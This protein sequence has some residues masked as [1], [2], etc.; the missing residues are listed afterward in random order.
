MVWTIL[1]CVCVFGV[2]LNWP[3]NYVHGGQAKITIIQHNLM[4]IDSAK[5]E[6]AFVHH[7]TD[8]VAMTRAG[9]APYLGP[10]TNADG[11][12][13]P[14]AGEVYILKTL[15]ESPEAQLTREV[16]T[17]PKGTLIRLVTNSQ[18]EIILPQKP[19]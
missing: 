5:N 9:I 13:K 18:L 4:L 10:A 6:W 19:Q 17:L 12:V 14:I 7:V 1:A 8:P 16:G 2:F 15:I 11:W 3:S